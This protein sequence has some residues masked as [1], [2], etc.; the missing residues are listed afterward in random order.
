MNIVELKWVSFVMIE[1]RFI[2]CSRLAICS[3]IVAI[4]VIVVVATISLRDWMTPIARIASQP[5][6]IALSR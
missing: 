3:I 6:W 4:I 2:L 5:Y 1:S